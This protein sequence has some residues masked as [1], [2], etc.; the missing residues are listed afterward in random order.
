MATGLAMRSAKSVGDLL[1]TLGGISPHRIRL[2]PSPGQAREKDVTDI[3]DRTGVICELVDGVLV[4]KVMGYLEASLAL[5]IGHLLQSFLDRRDLGLLAGADGALR[6]MPGLV[7][8]PDVSFVSWAK[9]PQRR[10]PVK[11]IPDLVPDLAIEILSESNTPGEMARKLHDYFDAGVVSVWL[12][13]LR[14]RT[15][16]VFLEPE[17]YT[18]HTEGE[19]LDGG[20]VLPGLNLAVRDIFARMPCETRTKAARVKKPGNG[21]KPGKGKSG[22]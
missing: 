17:V 21:K 8:A 18:V 13:D 2:H 5:W 3:L 15:V 20:D 7:R 16:S 14:A 19:V 4:E 12:V 9:L 11:P 22:R 10:V 1:E 6:L